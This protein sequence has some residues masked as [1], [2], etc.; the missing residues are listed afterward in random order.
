MSEIISLYRIHSNIRL[1]NTFI[2]QESMHSKLNYSF[3][4]L[5]LA[6]ILWQLDPFQKQFE[7]A[8]VSSLFLDIPKYSTIFNAILRSSPLDSSDVCKNCLKK[9]SPTEWRFFKKYCFKKRK[10]L[11]IFPW[12][13]ISVLLSAWCTFTSVKQA[14]THTHISI[15][16]CIWQSLTVLSL[17]LGLYR[18]YFVLHSFFCLC[19][20]FPPSKLTVN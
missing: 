16:V 1:L 11:Y 15:C 3:D 5:K 19:P 10:R 17:D 8:K 13:F 6:K 7:I 4:G 2:F 12:L 9:T 20:A 18:A 14:H